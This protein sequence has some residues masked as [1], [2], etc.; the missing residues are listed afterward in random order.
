MEPITTTKN[1]ISLLVFSTMGS[2][3]WLLS[4]IYGPTSYVAKRLFW[5]DIGH[6]ADC[7]PGAWLMIG[8]FN[9]VLANGDRSSN[10]RVDGGSRNMLESLDNI[11][12]IPIPSSG[13]FYTWSNHRF[14]RKR[15]NSRIDRG[16][17]NESWWRIFPNASIKLLPQSSSDHNLQVL[18]CYGHNSFAKRLFRFEVAWVEDQRSSWVVNQAW[19][20]RQHP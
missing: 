3:A 16:V 11:G 10:N 8:D 20:S 1:V 19:Y 7:F 14:G 2:P 13:F 17:A 18:S 9:G 15:V 4:A 5:E 6:E 12:M